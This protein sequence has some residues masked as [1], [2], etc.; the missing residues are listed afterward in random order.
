M[1]LD[2]LPQNHHML[3]RLFIKLTV[4]HGKLGPIKLIA[5]KPLQKTNSHV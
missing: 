1:L 2:A 5:K 3:P 4:R